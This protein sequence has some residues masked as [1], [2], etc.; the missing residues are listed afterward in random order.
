M[1]LTELK[2]GEKGVITRI[3]GQGLLRKRLSEMGFIKGKT[4]EAVRYA[5]LESPVVYRILNS[6]IAITPEIASL[7]EITKKELPLQ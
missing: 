3:N 7:I 1:R 4:I 2:K 6:E 5:P